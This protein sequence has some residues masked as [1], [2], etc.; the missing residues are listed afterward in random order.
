MNRLLALFAFLVFAGFVA[1]LGLEVPSI[2]LIIVIAFTTAL[3]A[4]D[5]ITSSGD[6]S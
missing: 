3:V 5:L 4:Y 1:I 6:K 2:D